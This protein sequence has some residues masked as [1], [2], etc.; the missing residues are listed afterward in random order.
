MRARALLLLIPATFVL[1]WASGFIVARLVLPSAEPMTFLAVRFAIAAAILAAAA[2]A[3]RAPWPPTRRAWSDAAVSGL[4]LHGG[5]L[6]G[7]FW[8][9]AHGL[10]TGIS[11]LVVSTQPLLTALVA[12]PLLGEHVSG[13]R[14]LGVVIG[15]SGAATVLAP[16]LVGLEPY[17]PA[18]LGGVT[19]AL[20]CITAG[21]IWHKR[22]GTA[23]DL[24]SAT[25]V[26]FAAAAALM[27][28]AAL[29]AES[30]RLEPTPE[31]WFGL[32]YSVGAL[33]I[34]AVAL[35]LIMIRRGAVVQV[36]SLL[37]LVPPITAIMGYLAFGERLTAAQ[38]VGMVLTTIGVALASRPEPAPPSP[39]E[40][41]PPSR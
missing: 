7:V 24:R 29:A 19:I 16:K 28:L 17:P 2:V 23:G 15:L 10:P 36:A 30:G 8:A 13:G 32:A 9:L 26:Q 20:L 21:T 25:A 38:L 31:F 34:G 18:A 37:F 5:Y 27:L 35:L 40:I 6:G 33:S 4:L 41:E 11:A 14:W 39:S 3:A 12:R 22:H 1:L